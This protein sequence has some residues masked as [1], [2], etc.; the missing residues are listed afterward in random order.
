MRLY[1]SRNVKHLE[2]DMKISVISISDGVTGT[3]T[4][5]V[6]YILCWKDAKFQLQESGKKKNIFPPYKFRNPS[7]PCPSWTGVR[8]V[9]PN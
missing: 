9:N 5:M 4:T 2:Y 8:Y 1:I 6:S 7:K 3:I